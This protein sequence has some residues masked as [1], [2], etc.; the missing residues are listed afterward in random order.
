MVT[1]NNIDEMKLRFL[2]MFSFRSDDRNDSFIRFHYVKDRSIGS[3]MKRAHGAPASRMSA[4]KS[5]FAARIAFALMVGTCSTATLACVPARREWSVSTMSAEGGA[6]APTASASARSVG[7][8]EADGAAPSRESDADDATTDGGSSAQLAAIAH[9]PGHADLDPDNDLVVGPPAPV[10]D[11]AARLEAAGVSFRPASLPVKTMDRGA[12]SCGAEQIVE[13][14][15]SPSAIRYNVPPLLT[16]TMALG[17]V[18]FERVLQEEAAAL[19]Q[20]KVARIQ[21]GGTYNCR[22]M[23]RFDMVSE[24]SFANAIDLS[25]LTLVNGVTIDVVRHFGNRDHEPTSRESQFL[26]RVARRAY[27]ENL[28]SVV[29]TPLFDPLHRDHFH[30]DMARYRVDG[31]Q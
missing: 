28:F 29:L 6:L 1:K 12:W 11:C 15:G 5:S 19:F 24:H 20:S 13:Y 10:P 4:T 7:S 22:R 8:M 21:H 25:R 17:I 9:E 2:M 26:R 18:R 3:P 23:A 14:R 31:A 30:L 16:C 27:D